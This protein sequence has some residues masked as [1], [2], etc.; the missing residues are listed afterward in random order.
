MGGMK[1]PYLNNI[2][3]AI[4]E[5]CIQRNIWIF[6]DYV[7]SKENPADQDYRISNIDTEWDIADYA[8]NRIIKEHGNLD[9]DLFSTRTN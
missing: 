4:W 9:I 3:R 6:A 7:A 1:F 2:T 8:Y 5:W